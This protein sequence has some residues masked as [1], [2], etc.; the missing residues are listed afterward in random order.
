MT[1]LRLIKER[2]DLRE[3]ALA[4][5]NHIMIDVFN[6]SHIEVLDSK[7][8]LIGGI[9]LN[10]IEV[11]EHSDPYYYITR[12]YLDKKD[13]SYLRQGIGREALIYFKE[14]YGYKITAAEDDGQR[15][16]DGSHLT[17]DAPSFV[18]KMIEE[19]VISR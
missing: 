9:Y 18:A 10:L 16:D 4:N 17:G 8:K 15:K 6:D 13:K 5:G 11:D 3:Y 19:G 14:I 7:S 12:M 2:P 1:R